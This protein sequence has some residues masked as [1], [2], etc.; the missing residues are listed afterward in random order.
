[1][2]D[3]PN[4]LALVVCLLAAAV[5]N[6]CA[7]PPAP[8]ACAFSAEDEA[9]IARS[10]TAWRY[11]SREIGG[12]TAPA[13]MQSLFFD[14]DCALLSGNALGG[15]GAPVWNATAH[16]EMVTL[17]NGEEMPASV[18]SFT[19]GSGGRAYFVMSTP[20]I[21][22]AGGVDGGPLGLETLMTAVL[23]HEASHVTQA[24]T[25]GR[26]MELLSEANNLPEEFND[27]SLQRRFESEAA[28]AASI[29]RETELLL[30]ASGA[31]DDEQ[32]RRLAREARALMVS[33]AESYFTGDDAYWREAE[34]IWLTFEGSAQ[35]LGYQW[36][37]SAEGDNVA[38]AE[39][40]PGFAQRSRWWSQ[41]EGFALFMAIDRLTHGAW[42][43]EVFGSG[44]RTALQILDEALA[45]PA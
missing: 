24:A 43:A 15:A 45:A 23:L 3:K 34:D 42:R 39:A 9:W 10:V 18:T 29:T 6:A 8:S 13:D 11:A 19:S 7:T 37:V 41:K 5:L 21:W 28:F 20:S 4:M 22:R 25:Y 31:A 26:R 40:M 14:D 32:A 2:L 44:E 33:R 27:D 17:P 1:M 12:F 38:V 16:G 36:V 30:Q 35:W